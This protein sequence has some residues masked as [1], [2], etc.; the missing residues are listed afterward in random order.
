LLLAASAFD[1][2]EAQLDE[3]GQRYLRDLE[4]VGPEDTAMVRSAW[5]IRHDEDF[6]RFVSCYVM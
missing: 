3:Y 1:V 2:Q 5:I 4:V 6:P